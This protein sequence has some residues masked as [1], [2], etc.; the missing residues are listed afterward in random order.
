MDFSRVT[1]RLHALLEL[2]EFY[3]PIRNDAYDILGL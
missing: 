1:E 2:G 3:A